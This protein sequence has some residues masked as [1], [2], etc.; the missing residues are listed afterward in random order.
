MVRLYRRAGGEFL[1]NS[2]TEGNQSSLRFVPLSDGGFLAFWVSPDGSDLGLRG[3]RFDSAGGRVG[4]EFSVNT[5]T[6][7]QQALPSAVLLSTG[8]VLVGWWDESNADGDGSAG[9]IRGQIFDSTGA[10]SGS[11]LLLVQI[12]VSTLSAKSVPALGA[13]PGGGFI[14]AW[15][16]D[17]PAGPDTSGVSIKARIYDSSGTAASGL[18][19]VNTT[20]FAGQ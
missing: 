14:M 11:E 10:P 8:S 19:S 17:D 6:T 16:Q 5:I 2:T 13:L 3:Q 15:T 4:V 7:G 12:P 20:T 18:I 1:V 9:D